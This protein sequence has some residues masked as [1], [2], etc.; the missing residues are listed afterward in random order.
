ESQ[1]VYSMEPR[2][3]ARLLSGSLQAIEIIKEVVVMN[4]Y[5]STAKFW[6]NQGVF[7][8]AFS[9]PRSFGY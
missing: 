4:V 8:G 1:C 6:N 5:E 2:L 3:V 7:S 9:Y